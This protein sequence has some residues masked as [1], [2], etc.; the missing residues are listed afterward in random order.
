M[1]D[2]SILSLSG[3]PYQTNGFQSL[4][5]GRA[6]QLRSGSSLK[7]QHSTDYLPPKWCPTLDILAVPEGRA[8]RLVRLSGGETIWRR[9]LQDSNQT[10]P[11]KTA[12]VTGKTTNIIGK[13]SQ[14]VIRA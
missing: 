5:G 13:D 2:V 1:T 8:L 10:T 7:Q 14:A 9:A 3:F 12:G 11:P 6:L 4:S